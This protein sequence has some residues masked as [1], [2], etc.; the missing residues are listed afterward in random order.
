MGLLGASRIP[1][2]LVKPQVRGTRAAASITLSRADATPI[3]SLNGAVHAH[4]D[5]ARDADSDPNERL[6]GRR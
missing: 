4:Y 3:Y 5:R 1:E 6:R 2:M